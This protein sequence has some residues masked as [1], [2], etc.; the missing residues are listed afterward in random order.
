MEPSHEGKRLI[1]AWLNARREVARR[2]VWLESAETDVVDSRRALAAWLLPDDAKAGEKIAVWYG[3][4]LIQ[5][6]APDL[7]CD[8]I[9]TIRTRGKTLSEG[10][11]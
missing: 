6:E 9:V 1:D 3:D 4:S 10:G 11:F 7:E 5:V 2:R 8:P